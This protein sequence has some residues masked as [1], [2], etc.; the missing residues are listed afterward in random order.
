MQQQ[1]FVNILRIVLH[2]DLNPKLSG[3]IPNPYMS[4]EEQQVAVIQ[5]KKNT[6]AR[7]VKQ[8]SPLNVIHSIMIVLSLI[9]MTQTT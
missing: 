7:N 6:A 9:F 8:V 4:N 5:I 1:D 2:W 3:Q